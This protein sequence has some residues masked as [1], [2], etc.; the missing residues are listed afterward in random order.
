LSKEK[1]ILGFYISGHPLA[2]YEE[3]LKYF[4]SVTTL[5]LEG[6]K[7]NLP[8]SLGGAVVNIKTSI[9]K[10][11][12]QMAFVTLEDFFGSAELI[13]FSDAYEK[14]RPLVFKDSMLLVKGRTSTREG[15]KAKV[16]VNELLHL[17]E[18]Y[19]KEKRSL[20]LNLSLEKANDKEFILELKK[21]LSSYPGNSSVILHVFSEEE[22]VKLKIKDIAV[23]LSFE[24]LQNLKSQV[25]KESF[26][27]DKA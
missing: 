10:K 14:Y 13:L 19:E 8:V 20:H 24:F 18:V 1:E 6:I 12:K 16:I 17:D 27:L 2:K 15:E 11:K 7:D 5:E 3:E 4:A 9:D 25:G 22:E 23:A 21:F 26:F